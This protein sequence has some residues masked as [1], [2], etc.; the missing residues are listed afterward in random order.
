MPEDVIR[1]AQ[2]PTGIPTPHG[3]QVRP[4]NAGVA[5]A[6]WPLGYFDAIY[7]VT[8]LILGSGMLALALN[9]YRRRERGEA[10]R[11]TRNLFAF[12]IFYLFALF[13]TLLV[14]VVVRAIAPSIW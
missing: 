6:P 2:R 7:G 5:V 11:A 8:S 9:V 3:S 13:A 14:E 10:L 1:A 4:E 12:S